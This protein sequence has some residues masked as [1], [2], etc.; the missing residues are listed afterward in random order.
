MYALFTILQ[1]VDIGSWML[2]FIVYHLTVLCLF[3]FVGYRQP[4]EPVLHLA[5]WLELIYLASK[6]RKASINQSVDRSIR[7]LV[8]QL[9]DL[10]PWETQEENQLQNRIPEICQCKRIADLMS[11]VLARGCWK[12]NLE[13][14][15]HKSGGLNTALS[16]GWL[17][18]MWSWFLWLRYELFYYVRRR[19]EE[20]YSTD[21]LL[22]KFSMI[23]LGSFPNCGHDGSRLRIDWRNIT[24]LDGFCGRKKVGCL[25]FFM[26][27]ASGVLDDSLNLSTADWKRNEWK[28]KGIKS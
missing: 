1:I 15:D 26:F 12:S 25:N 17:I 20:N 5:D 10:T 4:P 22:L 19:T 8:N 21:N 14:L 7:Q 6:C 3:L 2:T 11:F 16:S 18:S 9:E 23:L 24:V 13:S 27:V 28:K